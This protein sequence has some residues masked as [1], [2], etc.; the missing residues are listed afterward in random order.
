M[1]HSTTILHITDSHFSA[2]SGASLISRASAIAAAVRAYGQGSKRCLILI[3]GD[4]AYSGTDEE[5]K[6]AGDFLELLTKELRKINV[7]DIQIVVAPGNHDCNLRWAHAGAREDLI[8]SEAGGS[9]QLP[10][11]LGVQEEFQRFSSKFGDC[12]ALHPLVR[13]YTVPWIDG[14]KVWSINSAWGS[15]I[16]EKCGSMTMPDELFD[17]VPESQDTVIAIMHHPIGWFD[18]ETQRRL[19]RWMA[20]HFHFALFGHEHEGDTYQTVGFGSK[21]NVLYRLGQCF[22]PHKPT[23]SSGFSIYTLDEDAFDLVEI[24]FALDKEIY[25]PIEETTKPN[26]ALRR[27]LTS[28][29]LWFSRHFY[30]EFLNDLGFTLN[31]PR[32]TAQVSLDEVFVFPQLRRRDWRVGGRDDSLGQI[33]RS[34]FVVEISTVSLSLVFGGESSGLTSLAKVCCV[35]VAEQGGRVLY[36]PADKCNLGQKQQAQTAIERL[37]KDQT[38]VSYAEFFG[39]PG[40]GSS[41]A[42]VDGFDAVPAEAKAATLAALQS[43]FDRVVVFAR[44]VMEI[45][46]LLHE[47]SLASMLGSAQAWNLM[48]VGLELRGELIRKWLSIG[49]AAEESREVFRAN[50]TF[51]R[52]I[53]DQMIGRFMLPKVPKSVL[54]I[55]Q[56]LEALKD[57][58]SVI[59][60]GSQAYF[61]QS[62]ASD[63]MKSRLKCVKIDAAFSFLSLCARELRATDKSTLGRADVRRV[64]FSYQQHHLHELPL[65]RLLAELERAGIIRRR[66]DEN[67]ETVL[68]SFRYD[69]WYHFFLARQ[70]VFANDEWANAQFNALLTTVHSEEASNTLSFIAH[71][72][73]DNRVL[74]SLVLLADELYSDFPECDLAAGSTVLSDLHRCLPRLALADGDEH[75]VEAKH[76]REKDVVNFSRGAYHGE[77]E[78]DDPSEM[79]RAFKVV[80]VMGQILRAS[81]GSMTGEHKLKMVASSISLVRRLLNS[82]LRDIHDNCETLVGA[83]LISFQAQGF[84]A[85]KAEKAAK[86]LVGSMLLGSVVVGVERITSALGARDLTMVYNIYG[87]NNSDKTSQL[88]LLATKMEYFTDMPV[89]E[90][91]DFLSRLRDHE[92]LPYRILQVTLM[93]R[94]YLFSH[95]FQMKRKYCAKLGIAHSVNSAPPQLTFFDN[96]GQS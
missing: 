53:V 5:Y 87:Q 2:K 19:H 30:E 75:E 71:F 51:A 13:E 48:P 9:K 36:V 66:T 29:D 46:S 50:C 23:D 57:N 86:A 68:V 25:K 82:A 67:D 41:Y 31:H 39:A 80:Q 42:M 77:A 37:V 45:E 95:T 52:R 12:K 10:F 63:S 22:G 7:E 92:I 17:V 3:S 28:I 91:D 38:R 59:T 16:P 78:I 61:I 56:Q 84:S 65:E 60:D 6:I 8:N 83:A 96:K 93:K 70:I 55:L 47:R 32:R 34:E 79:N 20:G 1:T 74:D 90:L 14:L 35:L 76:D 40:S 81:T 72:S 89:A 85:Q 43:R 18:S 27:P 69:Y 54:L 94:L 26:F 62:I 58:R 64:H 15:L 49:W 88:F 11:C 44:D 33:F 24:N 21:Y 4:I 73:P